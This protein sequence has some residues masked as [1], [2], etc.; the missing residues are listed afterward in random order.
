LHFNRRPIQG[1]NGLRFKLGWPRFAKKQRRP[2][3]YLEDPRVPENTEPLMHITLEP[4]SSVFQVC[5]LQL[6]GKVH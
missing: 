6:S 1:S 5:F 2:F 3:Y 4:H